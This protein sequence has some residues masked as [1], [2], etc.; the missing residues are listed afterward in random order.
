M[1]ITSIF[2]YGLIFI[3]STGICQ[4]LDHIV[5]MLRQS[6]ARVDVCMKDN[7]KWCFIKKTTVN[8]LST[9]F[10]TRVTQCRGFHLL[11]LKWQAASTRYMHGKKIIFIFHCCTFIRLCEKETERERDEKNDIHEILTGCEIKFNEKRNVSTWSE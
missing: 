9:V 3:H 2:R 5:K 1:L 4:L 10:T 8:R 7:P 6:Y 11:G